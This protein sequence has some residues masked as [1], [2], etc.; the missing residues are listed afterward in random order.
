[1][2]DNFVEFSKAPPITSPPIACA[3]A[4]YVNRRFH[5]V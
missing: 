1:M 5:T 2:I 4:M 3:E